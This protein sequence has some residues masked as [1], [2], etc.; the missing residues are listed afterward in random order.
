MLQP[1]YLLFD[2]EFPATEESLQLIEQELAFA[3]EYSISSGLPWRG[4]YGPEGPR[5]PPALFMWP[6]DE[7]GQV[8]KILSPHGKW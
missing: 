2:E 5:P 6:A 1:S 4:Y 3:A 7:V 8:H